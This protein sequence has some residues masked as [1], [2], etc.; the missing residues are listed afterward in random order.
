MWPS[1][2]FPW[3]YL[4]DSWDRVYFTDWKRRKTLDPEI[5]FP[6]TRGKPWGPSVISQTT[7][8]WTSLAKRPISPLQIWKPLLKAKMLLLDDVCL[9]TSHQKRMKNNASWRPLG[10]C[11][12]RGSVCIPQD[13]HSVVSQCFQPDAR[14][15]CLCAR[16]IPVSRHCFSG[17]LKA[18]QSPS[19]VIKTS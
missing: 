10:L 12:Q 18:M 19:S 3:R 13:L 16:R 11:K 5:A 14:S 8:R 7:Q 1:G 9:L 4:G 6:Q 2:H 17:K 15:P